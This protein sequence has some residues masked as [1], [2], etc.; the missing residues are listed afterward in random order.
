MTIPLDPNI[1]VHRIL[2][3]VPKKRDVRSMKGDERNDRG[4]ERLVQFFLRI[5]SDPM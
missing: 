5:A 3:I 2:A 1:Y 4:Q